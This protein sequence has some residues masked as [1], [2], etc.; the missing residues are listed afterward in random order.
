MTKSKK[1]LPTQLDIVIAIDP[2]FDRLGVAVITRG[3]LDNKDTLLCSECISTNPKD[4]KGSRLLVIGQGVRRIIEEYKPN[5]MAIETLFFNKN[6]T[7]AIGVAEARGVVLYEASRAGLE[8]FEYSPQ[9]IKVATTGYGKADKIQVASMVSKLIDLP[10][11]KGKK[12][13]DELD[14]IALGITHL[15]TKRAI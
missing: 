7:S 13:D 5:S 8:I 1:S 6:I 11:S 4:N 2:G 14:A 3:A 9:S 12:L 15:A 10:K